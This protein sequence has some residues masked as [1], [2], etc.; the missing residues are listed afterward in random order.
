MNTIKVT[1]FSPFSIGPTR[2]NITTVRRIAEHLPQTCCQV[3]VLPL[4]SVQPAER[5]TFLSNVPPDLLHAFHA[6]HAGPA[7]RDAARRLGVPYIVTITGSDLFEPELR[8]HE[9]TRLA[10]QDAAAVTCF[11]QLV[12]HELAGA[13]PEIAEI[14]YVI[15]QGV[16]RLPCSHDYPRRENEFTILLP[17]AMRPVKG[18]T[19][20]IDALA[21]LAAD[22]PSIRLL[23]AGGEIDHEYSKKVR[24]M[25]ATLP[26]VEMLGEVKHQRMGDLFAASDLVLNS[27]IF[28]GGMANTLLEAMIIG[29]PVLARDVLGNRSLINHARNGWL[30]NGDED[31]RKLVIMMLDNPGLLIEIG[32]AGRNFVEQNCSAEKEAR[33]YFEVY[34]RLIRKDVHESTRP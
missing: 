2:G 3:S 15:P 23:L 14:I 34:K 31:L 20:A 5:Q 11:D 29:R 24:E 6:H 17:A 32:E 19:T 10:I 22:F 21:P 13:F 28:E 9:S 8:C 30:Y 27:S 26:W 4:D 16:A 18:I 7:A 12:A 1:L 25:V 33:S